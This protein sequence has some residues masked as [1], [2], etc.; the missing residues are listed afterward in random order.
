MS[1]PSNVTR[2]VSFGAIALALSA[3]PAW[4]GSAIDK[5]G[6]AD[7]TGSVEVSNVAGT[8]SVSGWDRNEIEVT[9]ELGDGV[10]R[11]EFTTTDKVTRIKV[12]LPDRSYNVEDSD[13][14][15]KV[16]AGSRVSVNT[17]SADTTVSGVTGAQSLFQSGGLMVA[18]NTDSGG[19]IYTSPDGLTWSNRGPEP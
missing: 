3:S 5:R 6:P 19:R 12:V 17:V 13:L 18:I 15:I 2:F 8:V 1:S 4:A 10:E 16:P 7:P 9:G 14:I 11:L